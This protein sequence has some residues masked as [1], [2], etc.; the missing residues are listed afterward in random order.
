MKLHEIT[1]TTIEIIFI[2]YSEPIIKHTII[3]R[4]T[5]QNISSNI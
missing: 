1:P 3:Q 2:A 5:L 4:I